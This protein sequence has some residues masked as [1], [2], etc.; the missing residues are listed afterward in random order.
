MLSYS[1][2]APPFSFGRNENKLWV[3]ERQRQRQLGKHRNRLLNLWKNILLCL[4]EVIKS[5]KAVKVI[6]KSVQNI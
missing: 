3:V 6:H 2:A 4:C 5:A 1:W